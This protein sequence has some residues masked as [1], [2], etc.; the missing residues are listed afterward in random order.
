M[1]IHAGT[2]DQ[3][4]QAGHPRDSRALPFAEATGGRGFSS[5]VAPLRL[6]IQTIVGAVALASASR[7]THSFAFLRPQHHLP[8]V[9]SKDLPPRVE[10]CVL[11]RSRG[12]EQHR[13]Q[14][15][16]AYDP[17]A[18]AHGNALSSLP[19]VRPEGP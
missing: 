16:D 4:R 9:S 13:D 3:I 1:K 10:R 18:D 5:S 17:V 11:A 8:G 15:H 7:L 19:G 2:A 12:C 6:R 14:E